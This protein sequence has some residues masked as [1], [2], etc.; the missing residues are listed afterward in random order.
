MQFLLAKFTKWVQDLNG[1][2]YLPNYQ[3]TIKIIKNN[4]TCDNVFFDYETIKDN[5]PYLAS[6]GYGD[7]F[8]AMGDSVSMISECAST[9]KPLYIFDEKN[10]STK[11]HRRFH[12]NLFDDNY[13]RKLES[14][15]NILDNFSN[16]KLQETQRVALLI[17]DN[18]EETL[19]TVG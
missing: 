19:S 9:G 8:I 6:L 1:Q 2:K 5:N 16:K 7:F 4:L 15:V 18:I 14:G 11:K 12:Q 13:A 3:K 17:R 10:I